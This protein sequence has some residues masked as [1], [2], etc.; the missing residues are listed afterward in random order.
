M[1][2]T[3]AFE[4]TA[5][6]TALR[7]AFGA[8]ATGVTVVTALDTAGRAVG[9]TANSFTS[10]SL[11]P[12][13]LLICLGKSSSNLAVFS[14]T[15]RFAINVLAGDQADISQRF[16]TPCEDRFAGVDWRTANGSAPLIA[17]GAAWFDCIRHSV[18]DAGDH[19]ILMGQIETFERSMR[20]PLIYLQGRYLEAP[21]A[22]REPENGLAN[23]RAKGSIRAGSI[24]GR[25]NQI[26]MQATK[27]GWSLPM[28]A[29]CAGFREARLDLED[30]LTRLGAQVHWNVLYSVFDDPEDA[31]TWVFFHGQIAEPPPPRDDLK[32]FALDALPLDQ[33]AAKPMRSMLRR[34][35]AESQSD[36][37]GVY[38]DAARHVGHIARFAAGAPTPW[39]AAY[40][41]EDQ[42]E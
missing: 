40:E 11:E 14:Q 9:F 15:G 37:F 26:L 33:V 2:K 10:V 5:L 31:G 28:S 6:K 38:V 22:P 7:D 24:L 23:R 42:I 19:I 20:A 3:E 30:A 25:A 41:D 32:F 39:H 8:F 12:P 16:A 4:K 34:Y 35:M 36:S 27:G 21:I 29:P 13:L 17:G 18:V 1:T